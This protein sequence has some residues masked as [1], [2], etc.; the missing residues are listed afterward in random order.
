MTPGDWVDFAKEAIVNA[1][2]ALI[3]HH[4]LLLDRMILKARF[5]SLNASKAEK[6]SYDIRFDLLIKWRVAA[7]CWC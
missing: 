1:G 2:R 6:I 5:Y 4:I 7:H 3:C